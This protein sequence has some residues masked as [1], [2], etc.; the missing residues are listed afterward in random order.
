MKYSTRTAIAIIASIFLLVSCSSPIQPVNVTAEGIA[1][2]GY[3]PVAYF[4]QGKPV[5]GKKEFSHQ[6]NSATWLFGNKMH[7]DKFKSNPARYAPQYGGY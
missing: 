6:W 4:T 2:K 7:L 1:I 5:Q 3:D